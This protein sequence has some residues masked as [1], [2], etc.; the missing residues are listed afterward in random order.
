[1]SFVYRHVPGGSGA[2]QRP[3]VPDRERRADCVAGRPRPAGTGGR[4]GAGTSQEVRHAPTSRRNPPRN[5][6]GEGVGFTTSTSASGVYVP[7]LV[8]GHEARPSNAASTLCP[9]MVGR[10]RELAQL[11]PRHHQEQHLAQPPGRRPQSP[12][13]HQ[14]RPHSHQRRHLGT[15][16]TLPGP[17]AAA[18]P[19]TCAHAGFPG[20]SA[21]A[22]SSADFWTANSHMPA[23]WIQKSKS[24]SWSED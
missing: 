19:G 23:T 17:A 9:V 21:Q 13:A 12:P 5:Q 20:C 15:R 8:V 2:G 16:I 3:N 6:Q 7:W 4:P 22:R 11:L 1:M 10:D 14:P 18:G 24:G